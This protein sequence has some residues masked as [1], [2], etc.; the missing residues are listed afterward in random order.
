MFYIDVN[1]NSGSFNIE[2]VGQ[3]EQNV[4]KNNKIAS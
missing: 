2:I 3:A 4:H 1:Q